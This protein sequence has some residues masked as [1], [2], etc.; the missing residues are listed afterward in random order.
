MLS[1]GNGRAGTRVLRTDDV[2]NG[3]CS[4]KESP[5]QGS[6]LG[7][8]SCCLTFRLLS[9]G[10]GYGDGAPSART[11]ERPIAH[12]L[13]ITKNTMIHICYS[14]ARIGRYNIRSSEGD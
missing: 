14:Q 9:W 11:R 2:Q 7:L 3:Q 1:A 10:A 6:C 4:K 12:V 8:L 5:K 13:G